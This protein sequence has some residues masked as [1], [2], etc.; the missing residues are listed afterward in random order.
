MKGRLT[1]YKTKLNALL[2]T[3]FASVCT[4]LVALTHLWTAPIIE[5]QK[6]LN[7][8]RKL[9]QV[10]VEDKYDSNPLEQCVMLQ[11]ATI[12]GTP[13][14]KPV[15]RT[16]LNGEPYAVIYQT[17]TQQGYNGLIELMVAVDKQG[18]VQG[19]RTLNHQETPGLFPAHVGHLL[20]ARYGPWHREIC[21][22]GI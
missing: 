9:E 12:T 20:W 16:Y 1:K 22:S 2:L 17:Q 4:L 10:L 21:L 8:L 13:H 15:Y 18:Q 3:A 5:E 7:I 14:P 6:Q 19:V 11:D